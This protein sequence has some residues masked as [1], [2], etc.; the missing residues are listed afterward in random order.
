M[1]NINYLTAATDTSC[2][3]YTARL[4]NQVCEFQ[5]YQSSIGRNATDEDP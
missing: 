5:V 3:R 1:H 4:G 2:H